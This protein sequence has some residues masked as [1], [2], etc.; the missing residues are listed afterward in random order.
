MEIAMVH[1]SNLAQ[2]GMGE[3]GWKVDWKDFGVQDE[4]EMIWVKWRKVP[5][6]CSIIPQRRIKRTFLWRQPDSARKRLQGKEL[7]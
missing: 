3:P 2:T 6:N 1:F 4:E 7:G 5:P